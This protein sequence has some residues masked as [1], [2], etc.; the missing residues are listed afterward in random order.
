MMLKTI[1]VGA[2]PLLASKELLKSFVIAETDISISPLRS[3]CS[4]MAVASVLLL[5]SLLRE[6]EPPPTF[7]K[8]GPVSE[9]NAQR[10]FPFLKV[11]VQNNIIPTFQILF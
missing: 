4:D 1:L 10:C 5:S 6:V 7:R 9:I 8:V 3:P 2:K 11:Y